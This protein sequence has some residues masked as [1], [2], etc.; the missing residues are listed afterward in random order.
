M[1]NKEL[2]KNLGALKSIRPDND[3]VL[4]TKAFILEPEHTFE[5]NIS[6]GF[7]FR[8]QPAL[9]IPILVFVIVGSSFGLHLTVQNMNSEIAYKPA[10]YLAMVEEK[11]NQVINT[12]EIAEISDMLDKATDKLAAATQDPAQTAVIVEHISTINR[13]VDELEIPEL[14]EKT[15][16]LTSIASE[17]IGNEIENTT[18]ALVENLIRML[19]TRELSD[20]QTELFTQANI[21]YNNKNY[22]KALETILM[23]TNE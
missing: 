19:E 13:R 23:L 6:R 8:L 1:H 7:L 17:S 4:S 5:K 18:Q 20:R 15:A 10:T 9:A 2:S 11:L 22:N 14:Q 12:E 21:D 16:V 3:W